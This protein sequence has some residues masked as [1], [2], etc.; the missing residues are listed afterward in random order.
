MNA[1]SQAAS[2]E[3]CSWHEHQTEGRVVGPDDDPHEHCSNCG[4]LLDTKD[5]KGCGLTFLDWSVQVF[6]DTISGP[7]ATSGGD[8]VCIP[9]A[10]R[11]AS[12]E[13]AQ[14]EYES[15]RDGDW[16]EYYP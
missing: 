15:A 7:A 9:C 10:R 3:L 2:K 16:R 6:D 12:D 1:P 4:R 14:E 13:R 8:L 5:C 11:H